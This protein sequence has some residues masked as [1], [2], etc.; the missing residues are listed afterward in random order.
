MFWDQEIHKNCS[1]KDNNLRHRLK[2]IVKIIVGRRELV[3][4]KSSRLDDS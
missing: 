2:K 4:D 3:N 1:T